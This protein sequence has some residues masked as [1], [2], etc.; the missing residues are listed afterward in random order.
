VDKPT[1]EN[2]AEPGLRD[3]RKTCTC[4]GTCRGK[5]GLG[6]GWRCALEV[7]PP[8]PI[9]NPA[10]YSNATAVDLQEG[11]FDF[12][13]AS[14]TPITT[15]KISDL[16]KAVNKLTHERNA[17]AEGIHDAGVAANLIEPQSL[18]GPQLLLL[19]KDFGDLLS[20][21]YTATP[22]PPEV[23]EGQAEN[24]ELRAELTMLREA[25][26]DSLRQWE[27]YFNEHNACDISDFEGGEGCM[28][29]RCLSALSPAADV[30]RAAIT[31]KLNAIPAEG[32]QAL[33]IEPPAEWLAE[34]SWD[35]PIP[36]RATPASPRQIAAQVKQA[37]KEIEA[38][39]EPIVVHG[40]EVNVQSKWLGGDPPF[41]ATDGKLECLD[42]R[43]D[44]TDILHEAKIF[45]TCESATKFAKTCADRA[46]RACGICKEPATT[47]YCGQC[48]DAMENP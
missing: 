37:A 20:L 17:L 33:V 10:V 16:L 18:T 4:T 2:P 3:R 1:S 38:A 27:S 36:Q 26:R 44:W 48:L 47:I 19:C 41:V 5:D 34:P 25:L 8:D 22:S 42:E 31:A 39:H 21:K 6:E 9:G 29:R 7:M 28:Y 15:P 30:M 40:R 35:E 45:S 14:D 43:G 13:P 12:E 11:V 46:R 23:I 32:I 24:A